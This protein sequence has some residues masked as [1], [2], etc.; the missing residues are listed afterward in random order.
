MEEVIGANIGIPGD[1]E[2]TLR[3]ECEVVWI[4]EFVDDELD[5]IV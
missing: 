4:V 5:D 1:T 2:K 3:G